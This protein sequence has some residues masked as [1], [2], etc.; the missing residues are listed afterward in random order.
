MTIRN[1]RKVAGGIVLVSGCAS[2]ALLFAQDHR[3]R[4][5]PQ[6]PAEAGAAR[7]FRRP[8]RGLPSRIIRPDG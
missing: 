6:R 2:V 1:L 4:G 3:R 7:V 5:L 8:R